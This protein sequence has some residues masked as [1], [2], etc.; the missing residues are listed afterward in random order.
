MTLLPS[1]SDSSSSFALLHE[2]VRRWIWEQRWSELRDVQE[3]A[4]R[5]IL[6]G[7]GDAIITAATAAGK[8]EAAFLPIC[9]TLVGDDASKGVQVLYVGPLKALINDQWRRL[10]GLCESLEIPVHR[11]HGD[12]TAAARQKLIRQPGGI[13]LITPE[14]LEAMF[15]RRG[16]DV[17]RIFAALRYVVIDE[18]H[19]F[20][21]SER[22]I[23][24]QSLLHRIERVLHRTV[25]RIGLSA[26][27]G[28]MDIAADFLRPPNRRKTAAAIVKS[29]EAGTGVKLRLYGFRR[30]LKP[31]AGDDENA[32][33]EDQTAQSIAQH[34]FKN[35][36]G[37]NNLVFANS[38]SNV[39]RYTDLLSR[40]C[41]AASL[42]QEFF[43]HHG[44]LSRELRFHVEDQLKRGDRPLTVI[45]TSTLEMGIDIGA[46]TS[47][48]QVGPPPNVA[49]LRQRLGRSGRRGE[50]AVLRLYIEEETVTGKTAPQSAIRT[51]F[52][53][54]MAMVNLL[55]ETWNEPPPAEIV[56]GSTLV[57]QFLSLIAQYGGITAAGGYAMLCE[58]GPFERVTK[59]MFMI[60]LRGLKSHELIEQQS[61]GEVHLGAKGEKFV[62]SYDFYSA[63]ITPD[64]YRL[65]TSGANLG[66][67]PIV[68]PVT[69][70]SFLIFAGRR[71]RVVDVDQEKHVIDLVPAAGGR[72]PIFDSGSRG[73]VHDRVRREMFAIYTATDVPPPYLDREA[74]ELLHEGR[75]NFARYALDRTAFIRCGDGALYFPWYGD[76]AMNTLVQQLAARDVAVSVE[77]PAIVAGHVTP[78]ALRDAVDACESERPVDTI[79][80]AANVKNKIEEKWDWCLDESTLNA[81]YASRRLSSN[82][83]ARSR[84]RLIV[85]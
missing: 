52:V 8:T 49:S 73:A 32:G 41:S 25:R 3:T 70:G 45:C 16:T 62:N 78:E 84:D 14:S 61:N 81:S 46:V 67:L 85:S 43:A 19:A 69:E 33:D 80:L 23:Q 55:L 66:T 1:E 74:S 18:L 39:E 21:G 60:L 77:G 17:A 75:E 30:G 50:P 48:A 51:Q 83:P 82:P 4:I 72:V 20:I 65:M 11:W 38:R 56:H 76:L 79:A 68:T 29:G 35:L 10:D 13:L 53:E 63:F 22:G 24:L 26:T 44:S 36:R 40:M 71:W 27:L 6:A 15:V 34:L 58:S 31:A 12:V 42:P 47:V 2:R 57:Q 64:E 28:D 59:Q 5:T 9:S 37:S 54:T 7:E